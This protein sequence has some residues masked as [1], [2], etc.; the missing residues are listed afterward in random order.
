MFCLFVRGGARGAGIGDKAL[1]AKF[2]I[3][4][5]LD[6]PSVGENLRK[7]ALAG[8]SV[9]PSRALTFV[10]AP[11]SVPATTEVCAGRP[12]AVFFSSFCLAFFFPF[13]IL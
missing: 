7:Q 5:L 8:F 11:V 9:L 12:A 6:V 4:A 13:G 1:L 10:L 2:G 3:E